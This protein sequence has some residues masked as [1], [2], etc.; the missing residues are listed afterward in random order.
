VAA[1]AA[2]ATQQQMAQQQMM[3]MA[4]AMQPQPGKKPPTGTGDKAMG[5]ERSPAEDQ[6]VMGNLD[7]QEVG[8]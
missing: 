5:A 7:G 6:A 4:G 2:A 8:A 1:E 3:A